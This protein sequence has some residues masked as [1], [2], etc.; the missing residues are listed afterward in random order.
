MRDGYGEKRRKSSES[1]NFAEH[2]RMPKARLM[3]AHGFVVRTGIKPS[4][5]IGLLSA[6]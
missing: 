3:H 2:I 5:V 4:W 6:L 1:K